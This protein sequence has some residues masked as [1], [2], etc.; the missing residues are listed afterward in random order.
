MNDVFILQLALRPGLQVQCSS[1]NS[2]PVPSWESMEIAPLKE[3]EDNGG[4]VETEK[5]ILSSK[6]YFPQLSEGN[7]SVVL[8]SGDLRWANRVRWA[9]QKDSEVQPWMGLKPA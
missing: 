7:L 2:L 9:R 1:G 4:S 5:A 6:K 3:M 8:K